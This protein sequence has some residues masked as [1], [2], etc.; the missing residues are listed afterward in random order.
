[1]VQEAGGSVTTMT[2]S[3]YTVFHRYIMFED[4]ASTL[5]LQALPL[6]TYCWVQQVN[7]VF[8]YGN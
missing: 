2:G 5:Y 3:P 1:M 4:W 8:K 7:S 6:S